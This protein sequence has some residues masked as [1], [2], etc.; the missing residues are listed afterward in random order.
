M[1]TK[2]ATYLLLFGLFCGFGPAQ[3][4]QRDPQ[5]D[6]LFLRLSQGDLPR[7]E[8]AA[9]EAQIWAIWQNSNS[10]TIDLLVQRSNSLLQSRL[11]GE[12]IE[13]LNRIIALSP[14]YAEAWNRRATVRY[15]QDNYPQALQDIEQTLRLEP[16]HFGALSGLGAILVAIG[17]DARA[18]RAYQQALKINPHLSAVEKEVARL[19]LAVKGRGI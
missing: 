7:A 15:T 5:L 9:I 8:A 19:N 3:A 16:R 10:A 6:A 17:Q 13:V 18:L 4:D 2:C 11:P 1:T 14:D 12:A